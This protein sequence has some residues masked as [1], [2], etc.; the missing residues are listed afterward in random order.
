MNVEKSNFSSYTYTLIFYRFFAAIVKFVYKVCK[1]LG[2]ENLITDMFGH[3]VKQPWSYVN[4]T[5]R[6]PIKLFIYPWRRLY[7]TSHD[8]L[9]SSVDEASWSKKVN[10][11]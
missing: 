5:L 8:Q 9:N 3:Y 4:Q 1:I 11:R 7:T 2:R 10:L 6:Q